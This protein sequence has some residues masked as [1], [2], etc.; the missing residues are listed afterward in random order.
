LYQRLAPANR[1]IVSWYDYFVSAFSVWVGLGS[2]VGLWR[3]AQN[4]PQRQAGIWV[5]AG[6]FV[7][8]F[9]LAGARLFYVLTNWPYF[10]AHLLE[11]PQVW[12]GGL[13]WPG[14][15]G[16]AVVALM[17]LMIQ[18][19]ATSSR[20]HYPAHVTLGW[21][22]DRLYP[23][24]PPLAITIWLGSWQTGVAYGAALPAGAFGSV[25]SLDENG[26]YSP[27]FPL[28]PLAALTLLAFFAFLETRRKPLRPAGWLSGL[29]IAGLLLNLLA[30][31]LLRADPA[32]HWRG[33]R[34]DSWMAIIYLVLL[35]TP[36]III[37]LAP[38]T[39][40]KTPVH[41]PEQTPS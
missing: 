35:F 15:L 4:A 1:V 26:V 20:P 23:L 16:G 29:A 37:S 9:T 2:I 33:L 41:R 17:T 28:Q 8:A 13:S 40:R 11:A 34:L 22:G 30:A 12:L 31:S 39:R 14:A 7:L 27:R 10:S 18:Y 21:L 36:V 5:N 38:R 32:P 6:L 25:P 24:L 3:V 19:R